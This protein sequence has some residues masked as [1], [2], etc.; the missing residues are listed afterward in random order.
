[1]K[2]RLLKSA[3][4]SLEWRAVAFIITELFFWATTGEL[5]AATILALELQLILLVAHFC[6]YYVRESNVHVS[7]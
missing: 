1:M 2:E 6:W 3:T 5:W 4:A 7:R